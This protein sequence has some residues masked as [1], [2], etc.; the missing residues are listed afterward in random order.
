M[1]L[2]G[3]FIRSSRAADADRR[4]GGAGHRH[5]HGQPEGRAR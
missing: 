5:H 3:L 1:K 4:T 2:R